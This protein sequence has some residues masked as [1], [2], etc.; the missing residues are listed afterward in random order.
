MTGSI[1]VSDIPK[2]KIWTAK[3]G[4]KYVSIKMWINDEPD[5][6]GNN[7]SVQVGQTKEEIDQKLKAIYIGNLKN[8]QSEQKESPKANVKSSVQNNAP[9]IEDDLPF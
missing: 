3:S 1:C 2:E 9:E 8:Y 5:Q 4:K 6:Y 7:A